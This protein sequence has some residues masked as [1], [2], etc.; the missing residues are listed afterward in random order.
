MIIDI[1][2]SLHSHVKRDY[3]LRVSSPTYSK[4]PIA[5]IAKQFDFDYWDGN[6]SVCYGGYY[7]IP[8]YWDEFI[9]RLSDR[10]SLTSNSSV[11]DIG[12]G[13]GF[14]A[15]D[16]AVFTGS[17]KV[18]GFDN[19]QYAVNRRLIPS[20]ADIQ[21]FD[22]TQKLPFADHHFDLVVSLMTLHN[23]NLPEL[24]FSLSEIQRVSRGN[25]FVAVEGY[26]DEHTKENLLNWQVT[27]ESFFTPSEWSYVCDLAGYAGDL[28]I[29]FFS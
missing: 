28:D 8:N 26:F 9:K 21:L 25:S 24:V 7:Y 18:T 11:L 17:D 13:K 19:S 5:T 4:A 14:F 1:Y 15:H 22:C 29:V 3:L 23:F 10:Y 20:K 27:C 16:L 2:S 12:C 6:R